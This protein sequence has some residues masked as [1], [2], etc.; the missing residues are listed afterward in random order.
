MNKI[1]ISLYQLTL[2]Q[3]LW[4]QLRNTQD[5]LRETKAALSVSEEKVAMEVLSHGVTLDNLGVCMDNLASANLESRS[6]YK[7]IRTE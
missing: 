1:F 2:R 5:W 6:R 4:A 3:A 7:I